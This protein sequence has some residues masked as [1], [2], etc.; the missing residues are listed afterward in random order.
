MSAALALYRRLAP[1]PGGRGL[2]S[3]LICFRAPYFATIAPRFVV[4][5]PGRCEAR[6]RDRRRVHN[7]LGTVHAIALC[8]LAELAAGVMTDATIPADMRWIPKG[9]SVEYLKKAVGTMHGIAT[10]ELA[11]PVSGDG[12]EWPVK[13]EVADDAGEMVFRARVLMWVS[14]RKRG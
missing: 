13:V 12:Y 11:A 5:E 14:P 7:H 4:L 1:W 3:R 2:Y 8:N 9:M 10:P 6:I